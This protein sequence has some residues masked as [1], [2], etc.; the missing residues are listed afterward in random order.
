M[1]KHKKGNRVLVDCEFN[2]PH[3]GGTVVVA[4]LANGAHVDDAP[5]DSVAAMYVPSET[6]HAHPGV[7][8]AD[9]VEEH[10]L[11]DEEDDA[12]IQNPF[13]CD[14]GRMTQLDDF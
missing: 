7:S 2:R 1:T 13:R 11:R 12:R 9:L 6:V 3:S 8:V 10:R 5:E 4:Q 14:K